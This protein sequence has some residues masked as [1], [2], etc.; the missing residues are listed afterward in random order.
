MADWEREYPA[1]LPL[2]DDLDAG[3]SWHKF[4]ALIAGLSPKSVW[5]LVCAEEPNVVTD[6]TQARAAIASWRKKKEG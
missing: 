6:E 3:L 4:L 1:R 2:M 5:R